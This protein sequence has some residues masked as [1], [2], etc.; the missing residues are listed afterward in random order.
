MA[1]TDVEA[2]KRQWQYGKIRGNKQNEMN[3]KN[4]NWP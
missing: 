2:A 4:W 3:K 1:M